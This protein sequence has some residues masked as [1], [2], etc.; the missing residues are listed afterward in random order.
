MAE[1]SQKFREMGA[2]VYVDAE[3]AKAANKALG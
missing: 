2:E 1:M 3:K